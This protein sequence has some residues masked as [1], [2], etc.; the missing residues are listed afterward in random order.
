MDQLK[1]GSNLNMS[2]AYQNNKSDFDMN[3]QDTFESYNA[4]KYSVKTFSDIVTQEN[5]KKNNISS[6]SPGNDPLSKFDAVND[7]VN[8]FNCKTEAIETRR[9]LAQDFEKIQTQQTPHPIC[10]KDELNYS[11]LQEKPS[12]FSL[13]SNQH[14]LEDYKNASQPLSN[15]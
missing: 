1:R 6:F 4:D 14:E 12:T 15:L 13:N 7:T 9:A 11:G 3:F 10:R 2:S 5:T 8:N